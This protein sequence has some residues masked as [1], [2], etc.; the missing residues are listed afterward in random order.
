[1]LGQCTR[2]SEIRFYVVMRTTPSFAPRLSYPFIHIDASR[3]CELLIDAITGTHA[4]VPSIGA[5]L[6]ACSSMSTVILGVRTQLSPS[7][8]NNWRCTTS[9]ASPVA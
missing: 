5:S 6:H 9:H 4:L 7:R 1:M 8:R 3:Q 2:K